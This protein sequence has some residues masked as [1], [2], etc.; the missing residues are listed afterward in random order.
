[1]RAARRDASPP[2]AAGRPDAPSPPRRLVRTAFAKYNLSIGL[3]LS[4]VAG[5]VF[6]IGHIGD[7]NEVSLL[8]ALAGTE[9]ALIDVGV[10]ITPGAGVGAAVKY[11]QETSSVI[12]TRSIE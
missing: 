12:R 3:G 4:E 9:M 11:F 6:R 7:L 10:K 1:M 5:K 8:G 2:R